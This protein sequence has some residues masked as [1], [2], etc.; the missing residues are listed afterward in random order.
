MRVWCKTHLPVRVSHPWTIFW[1]R[2]C[3]FISDTPPLTSCTLH[4]GTVL[5]TDNLHLFDK[6]DF[7][8]Q[9]DT[10]I[11]VTCSDFPHNSAVIFRK[12]PRGRNLG[13]ISPRIHAG[14]GEPA[15][16]YV[17]CYVQCL[18]VHSQHT[19]FISG[20][21]WPETFKTSTCTFAP[22]YTQELAM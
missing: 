3:L 7:P 22:T 5:D 11:H 2:H 14:N 4:T 16:T 18:Y 19:S 1:I 12:I 6:F 13:R 15:G 17:R 10:D 20:G 9:A 8:V 21:E